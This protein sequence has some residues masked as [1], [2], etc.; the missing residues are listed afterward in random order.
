MSVTAS[1]STL[2]EEA[3]PWLT[4]AEVRLCYLSIGGGMLVSSVATGRMLD[5]DH[6]RVRD[7]LSRQRNTK[8]LENGNLENNEE[9]EEGGVGI[10]FL[11]EKARLRT[12]PVYSLF[13]IGT[14]L[15]YGWC[16]QAKVSIAGPLILQ[17]LGKSGYPSLMASSSER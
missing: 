1:I 7:K 17:F 16:V 10:D 3:Y 12:M 4:E 2:F 13:F 15:G 11:V 6:R 5:L 14:V 9:R 8:K